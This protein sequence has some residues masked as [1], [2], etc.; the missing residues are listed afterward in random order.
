MGGSERV[1]ELMTVLS[2]G[3]E[4]AEM[5]GARERACSAA[6]CADLPEL[7]E[8]EQGSTFAEFR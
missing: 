6:W 7:K 4:W 3:A 8:T 5:E 2:A 1:S